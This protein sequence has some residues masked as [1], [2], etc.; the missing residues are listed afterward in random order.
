MQND[1]NSLFRNKLALLKE[2]RDRGE[3]ILSED[4]IKVAVLADSPT[5]V[6]GF[7][8]VCREVLGALYET[9]FYDFDV[10]GI[11][12]AGDPHELPYRIFPAINALMPS[13]MY[14][15]VFG[16]QRFLDMLGEGRFDLVWV[17]QDSFIVEELSQR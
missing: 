11:N 13:G 3:A 16:R 6:T 10:V 9:G 15:D 7:G 17:L 4:K 2:K 8:N 5:V 1:V 12:Y 14:H